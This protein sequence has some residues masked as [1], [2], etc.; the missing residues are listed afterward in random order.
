MTM[1]QASADW[2]RERR[3]RRK[4]ARLLPPGIAA[5]IAKVR[6]DDIA[7]QAITKVLDTVKEIAGQR[8]LTASWWQSLPEATIKFVPPTVQREI[9]RELETNQAFRRQLR[10]YIRGL[11]REAHKE[12]LR[13]GDFETHAGDVPYRIKDGALVVESDIGLGT[14]TAI[15]AEPE[16]WNLFVLDRL[17]AQ[18]EDEDVSL[19]DRVRVLVVGAGAGGFARAVSTSRRPLGIAVV[20]HDW[21]LTPRDDLLCADDEP[22]GTFD[23]GVVVVPAPSVGGASN[24]RRIYHRTE[25]RKPWPFDPAA[26]GPSRWLAS[27]CGQL[28]AVAT[29]VRPVGSV[30][31]LVPLGVRVGEGYQEVP[32]LLDQ[33]LACIPALGLEV[34]ERIAVEEPRPVNQPFVGTRRPNR[35]TLVCRRLGGES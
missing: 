1:A 14:A 15:E 9:L 4:R 26:L 20:Q 33:V 18:R 19:H 34:L 30:Y 16:G 2:L 29:Q 27:V 31:C 25:D 32:G 23:H 12:K 10:A 8:R 6:R 28:E 21:V 5:D 13:S 3:D 11:L 7:D 24:H 35:V 22:A 17:V